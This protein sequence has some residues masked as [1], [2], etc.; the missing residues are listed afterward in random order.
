MKFV[1]PEEK[2][3][4]THTFQ[5]VSQLQMTKDPMKLQKEHLANLQPLKR[6]DTIIEINLRSIVNMDNEPM[7]F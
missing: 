3:K 1:E 2:K 4:M 6:D 7:Y 5:P